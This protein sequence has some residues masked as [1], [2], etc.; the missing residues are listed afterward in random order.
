M[1]FRTKR[2]NIRLTGSKQSGGALIIQ[3]PGPLWAAASIGG[4]E[5]YIEIA[6]KV[7]KVDEV[8]AAFS[9]K[10]GHLLIR[11]MCEFFDLFNRQRYAATVGHVKNE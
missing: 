2:R 11:G 9:L 6:V 3:L 1:R 10:M 5:E 7:R 8:T 4:N